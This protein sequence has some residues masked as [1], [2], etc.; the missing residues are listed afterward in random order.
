[1]KQGARTF[2]TPVLLLPAFFISAV[3]SSLI[4][5]GKIL[6]LFRGLSES[7][8]WQDEMFTMEL[9]RQ[10]S[11]GNVIVGAAADTHPITYTVLL[12]WW[13]HAFG[14]DEVTARLLSAILATITV[15]IVVFLVRPDT[16]WLARSVSAV[17]V[18]TSFAWLEHAGE[19]RSYALAT[20]AVTL[21]V[22]CAVRLAAASPDRTAKLQM[23][24]LTAGWSASAIHLG[25]FY[26]VAWTYVALAVSRPA[27]WRVAVV[28]L[29]GALVVVAIY[30][31]TLSV[32]HDFSRSNLLFEDDVS[33]VL[34][35]AWIGIRASARIG[36]T[37][38]VIASAAVGLLSILRGR[39]VGIPLSPETAPP[40]M[41]LL[42]VI[43]PL[44]V[45][46]GGGI[47]SLLLIPSFSY[48]N[49]QVAAP[50]FWIGGAGLMT[51]AG[52]RF[53]LPF[54]VSAVLVLAQTAW[55]TLPT[56]FSR[57]L[58]EREDFR[59]L[60]R[61]VSAQTGCRGA[62]IPA[63]R[64]LADNP[65][66]ETLEAKQKDIAPMLNKRFSFYDRPPGHRYFMW[67]LPGGRYDRPF[68]PEALLRSRLSGQSPC[69]ILAVVSDI[70]ALT[71]ENVEVAMRDAALDLGFTPSSVEV[72]WFPHY[73]GGLP[74]PA[75]K[76]VGL[77]LATPIGA[78][79][80]RAPGQAAASSP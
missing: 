51:L 64:R 2:R 35:S 14:S 75:M 46:V 50:L 30:G 33:G 6:R 22:A 40:R 17:S 48:R 25:A 65:G 5:S 19:A 16:S 39:R 20:M 77:V 29:I 69:P 67:A 38:L 26:A 27:Q 56:A 34:R 72:R 63:L 41:D 18:V 71:T 23:V 12:H 53:P 21:T 58:P 61:T 8:F 13:V 45:A 47:A 37:L 76:K 73:A 70:G 62:S 59:L 36:V 49:V 10:A 9:A 66:I 79:R 74:G 28:G 11:L 54:A 24:L 42:L 57:P 1:M 43:G 60:G 32:F 44:A 7:S 80:T 55:A 4:V 78:A 15:L 52:R 68:A 3:L 31:L